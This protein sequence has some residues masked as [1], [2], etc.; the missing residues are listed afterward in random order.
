MFLCNFK[1]IFLFLLSVGIIVLNSSFSCVEAKEIPNEWFIFQEK[2]VPFVIFNSKREAKRYSKKLEKMYSKPIDVK[3]YAEAGWEYNNNYVP[4]IPQKFIWVKSDYTYET[5]LK[6]NKKYSDKY[7]TYSAN[8]SEKKCDETRKAYNTWLWNKIR[9]DFREKHTIYSKT[10]TPNIGKTQ[11]FY[12]EDGGIL[13]IYEQRNVFFQYQK[14]L[15]NEIIEEKHLKFLQNFR[16]KYKDVRVNN[17]YIEFNNPKET[18]GARWFTNQLYVRIHQSNR[19]DDMFYPYDDRYQEKIK[20]NAKPFSK[21]EYTE[22]GRYYYKIGGYFQLI[23]FIGPD[24]KKYDS[25]LFPSEKQPDCFLFDEK[26]QYYIDNNKQWKE[27]IKNSQKIDAT[28]I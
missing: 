25:S 13:S 23:S 12:K 21:N 4:Y 15:T 11:K 18:P 22:S 10:I 8:Y 5:Y 7:C 26:K 17:P 2:T 3:E 14:P 28:T 27:Y 20:Y 9:N 16:F 6:N 24:G 19:T 1:N